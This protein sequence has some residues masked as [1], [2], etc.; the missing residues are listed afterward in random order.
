MYDLEFLPK[1]YEML[2]SGETERWVK[3]I[4]SAVNKRA[5]NNRGVDI[6]S[7]TGIF[8]RA[9][10]ASGLECVGVEPSAAMLNVAVQTGGAQYVMA[11]MRRLKGFK[12]LGFAT[13]V[14]DV[15]NYIPKKDLTKAFTSVS[16]C[17][18][19]SGL[20]LFDISSEYKLKNV[21][22]DNMFGSDDE[23][24]S[25]MWFNTLKG[26]RILMEL[27]YFIKQGDVYLRREDTFTQYVYRQSEITAA[28]DASGFDVVSVTGHLGKPLCENSERLVFTA[29]KR[30]K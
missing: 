15:V 28:L 20:F 1:C 10:N 16:A 25:Y 17:L 26:D 24:L 27:T 2:M 5:A 29:K 23:D 22:A 8:T 6:G 9:L 19:A 21:L 14:N 3:F 12:N 18:C 7:G 13:A 4:V 30:G 11:D